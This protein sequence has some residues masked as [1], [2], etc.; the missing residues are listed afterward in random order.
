MSRKEK[1]K[2]LFTHNIAL[3][4]VSIGIA[5]MIWVMV[6]NIS[7]PEITDNV[8]AEL[9]VQYTDELTGIG[10]TYS[11]NTTNVRISYKVRSNFRRL[12]HPSN[13][14]AYIDLRDYSV[15]GAV[16][17]YVDV[18]DSVS[19]YINSISINPIVVHVETEDMVERTFDVMTEVVGEPGEGKV[20]GPVTLSAQTLTLYGPA[21]DLGK[22]AKVAIDIPV[23]GALGDISGT[24][25]PVFYDSAGNKVDISGKSIV[26][27]NISYKASIYNTKT[28]SVNVSSTGTPADGYALDRIETSP[29]FVSVYGPQDIL[30]KNDTIAIPAEMLD[31]AGA[32]KNVTVSLNAEQYIPE[33]LYIKGSGELSIAAFIT[34]LQETQ[35]ETT[36]DAASAVT[37][38]TS[39]AEETTKADDETL[40]AGDRQ[41]SKLNH[42]TAETKPNIMDNKQKDKADDAGSDTDNARDRESQE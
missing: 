26:K 6:V 24:G 11:L 37:P 36:S 25:K 9:S 16:P 8:T 34:K 5:F 39:A 2:E 38:E 41:E 27:D 42:E 7:N 29:S 28:L 40:E 31:I 1:L 3:K 32:S 10:K 20:T 14:K 21:S 23:D 33:G 19:S 17:V 15:T 12:I 18:D 30:A 22:I 35:D 13:F 4:L